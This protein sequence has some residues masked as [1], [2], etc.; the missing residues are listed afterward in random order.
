MVWPE[1]DILPCSTDLLYTGAE[2]LKS[3]IETHELSIPR[4]LDAEGNRSRRTFF[5]VQAKV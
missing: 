5:A 4:I 1:R 2:K 3:Y